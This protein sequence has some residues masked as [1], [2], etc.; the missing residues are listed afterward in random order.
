MHIQPEIFCALD[1]PGMKYLMEGIVDTIIL[2]P[3]VAC[4]KSGN[5]NGTVLVKGLILSEAL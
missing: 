5:W 3:G 4:K 2:S 1:I